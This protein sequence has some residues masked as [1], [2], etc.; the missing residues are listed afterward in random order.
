M[1]TDLLP[2]LLE[3]VGTIDTDFLS[4]IVT[5]AGATSQLFG[6][7]LTGN[8]ALALFVDV[9]SGMAEGVSALL[10][11]IPL[12]SPI[13]KGLVTAFG[14]LAVIGAV[15]ALKDFASSVFGVE[16]ALRTMVG[17]TDDAK[18][19]A[20]KTGQAYA[21][22]GK[23]LT[24]AAV[25]LASKAAIDALAPSI[26][27]AAAAVLRAAD[28]GVAFEAQFE[29]LSK[30]GFF[31]R[32]ALAAKDFLDNPL[33][34]TFRGLTN[35]TGKWR[36]E[37]EKFTK[38]DFFKV[39]AEQ[40][41]GSGAR[42]IEVLKKQGLET[43]A[44]ERIL[45]SLIDE[46]AKQSVADEEVNRQVQIQID[47]IKGVNRELDSHI[48]KV[49]A[50][51]DAAL[52]QSGAAINV[53]Q[54]IDDLTKSLEENG[55]TFD[56]HEQKGRNNKR[57][58]DD[59]IGSIKA[60]IEAGGISNDRKR[61]LLGHLDELTRS[62]YPGAERAAGNL[63][64]M[65]NSIERTYTATVNLDD[66]EARQRI[67]Q[68]ERELSAIENSERPAGD[69]SHQGG[70]QAREFGG[71]VLRNAAYIVGEKRP[72]LFVP[73]QNG[74]IFPDVPPMTSPKSLA[75][76]EGAVAMPGND[77]WDRLL[78]RLGD[79]QEVL[80]DRLAPDQSGSDPFVSDAPP[81]PPAH[82]VT[83]NG[84]LMTVDQTFGPGSAVADLIAAMRALAGEE[85]AKMMEQILTM[86]GA[87]VGTGGVG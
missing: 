3:V 73:D 10:T 36:E 70:T 28:A 30:P 54:A 38:A 49:K 2:I 24:I 53:E 67:I 17:T 39:I 63:R 14:A 41:V 74:V 56:I 1:R 7:L 6:V 18:F 68:L 26:D 32:L 78:D 13:L 58:L 86:V 52:K 25:V 71:R 76:V 40:G 44:Y 59:L 15:A 27:K 42:I 16:K 4:S 57:A 81:P 8:P 19:A 23:A 11:D 21:I 43:G 75:A 83:I 65:L 77:Q 34:A 48:E 51:T 84:P 82:S 87:G 60:E 55:N 35:Q 9:L 50:A 79:F 72:E 66:Q 45:H 12:L 5:L 37:L 46:K 29:K 85:V 47:K 33:D 22:F 64:D 20:T 62:G 31:S 69:P 61:E 80:T